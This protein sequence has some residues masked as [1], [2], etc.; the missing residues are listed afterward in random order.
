MRSKKATGVRP[1]SAMEGSSAGD[2]GWR[3]RETAMR[4]V[5]EAE[6]AEEE[7]E[8]RELEEGEEEDDEAAAS[9]V[10]LG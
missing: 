6:E 9:V 2:Q 1:S 4:P 7:E 5:M 10:V 3:P 8:E